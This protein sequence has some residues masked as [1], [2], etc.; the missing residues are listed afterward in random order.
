MTFTNQ[1]TDNHTA[2]FTTLLKIEGA[3]A[4]Y[5][6]IRAETLASVLAG[7]QKLV[8]LLATAESGQELGERLKPSKAMRESC[9]LLCGVPQA[10]SYAV[11]LDLGLHQQMDMAPSP[12]LSRIEQIWSALASQDQ[13]QLKQLLPAT[14]AQKALR[15]IQKFL[16]KEH[17]GLRLGFQSRS[18][19]TPAFLTSKTSRF[20]ADYLAPKTSEDAVMTVTGELQRIDFAAHQL[21]ILYP[22][23]RREIVCTYLAEIEENIIESRKEPIQVTGRFVLDDTG[24]PIK[25]MD[26]TRVEPIDLSPVLINEVEAVN[27]RFKQPLEL[28]P[29]LD[30]D[31]QQYLC[32]TEPNIGL[33]IFALNR[34]LLF[35][36]IQEQLAMLWQEYALA[37]DQ[38][39][40]VDAK[41]IQANLLNLVEAEDAKA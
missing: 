21:T 18:S 37:A 16:P 25:L 5:H 20:I 8:Y 23:T 22:P 29:S 30:E 10:G 28:S 41:I 9:S 12:F 35:A 4:E 14:I 1:L 2:E 24:N 6:E 31:S 11:P 7:L 26:V 32:I 33:Q 39:L 34:E 36:E 15:E 13:N 38:T 27:V 40:D 3:E 19:T 17:E